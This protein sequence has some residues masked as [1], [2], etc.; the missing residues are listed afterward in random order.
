MI[1]CSKS[2]NLQLTITDENLAFHNCDYKRDGDNWIVTIR[3]IP[4]AFQFHFGP[5]PD[6]KMN[7]QFTVAD[8]PF[9]TIF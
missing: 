9:H 3:A 6:G 5:G 1:D 2:L 8:N 4:E 7:D